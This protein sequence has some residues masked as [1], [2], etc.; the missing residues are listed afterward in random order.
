MRLYHKKVA[1]APREGKTRGEDAPAGGSPNGL[2]R[3]RL[4]LTWS[5]ILS[6][7]FLHG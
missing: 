2:L 5:D 1:G 3:R 4:E 7:S 6:R